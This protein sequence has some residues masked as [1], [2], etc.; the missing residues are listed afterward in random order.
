MKICSGTKQHQDFAKLVNP[1][2]NNSAESPKVGP[3]PGEAPGADY[4]AWT[5]DFQIWKPDSGEYAGIDADM[6]MKLTSFWFFCNRPTVGALIGLGTDMAAA[7]DVPDGAVA[8]AEAPAAT[9]DAD[10]DGKVSRVSLRSLSRHLVLVSTLMPLAGPACVASLEHAQLC[11]ARRVLLR[12][13]CR[14][15]SF[16][17]RRTRTAWRSSIG[18]IRT[19]W[20][21]R[22]ASSAPSSASASRCSA[23]RRFSTTKRPTRRPSAV[24]PCR[25]LAKLQACRVS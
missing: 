9:E 19:R 24:S 18:R 23:W 3:R 2:P 17:C 8:A 10:D 7:T 13:T 6:S 25:C 1:E 12:A 4:R 22:A 20:C 15:C 21:W 14:H 5:L 16:K 11:R